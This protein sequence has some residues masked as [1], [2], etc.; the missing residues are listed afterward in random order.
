M[1]RSHTPP[2]PPSLPPFCQGVLLNYMYESDV[3]MEICPRLKEN[4]WLC[5]YGTSKTVHYYKR[6]KSLPQTYG[7]IST[8]KPNL[9]PQPRPNGEPPLPTYPRGTCHSK[10]ALLWFPSGLRVVVSS[11]NY[12]LNDCT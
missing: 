5:V 12:I 1:T 11:A 6:G 3:L 9:K 4:P 7:N 8:F 2:P 10:M